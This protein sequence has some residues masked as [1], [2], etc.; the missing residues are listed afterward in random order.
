MTTLTKPIRREV[1]LYGIGPVVVEIDPVSK[2]FILHEKGC[3]TRYSIPILAVYKHAIL[4]SPAKE[5]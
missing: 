5:T 4:T 3:R 1:D 2:C